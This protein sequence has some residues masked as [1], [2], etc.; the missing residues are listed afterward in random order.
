MMKIS[1]KETQTV[2]KPFLIMKTVNDAEFDVSKIQKYNKNDSKMIKICRESLKPVLQ[3]LEQNDLVNFSF[4]WAVT[5]NDSI[6][7]EAIQNE[8]LPIILVLKKFA[9]TNIGNCSLRS[10]LA[11]KL[12]NIKVK[13]GMMDPEEMPKLLVQD[14]DPTNNED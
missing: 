2:R 5:F 4:D 3:A 12:V 14:E 8:I 11:R 6:F 1:K 7:Q 9:R 10:V 13:Y